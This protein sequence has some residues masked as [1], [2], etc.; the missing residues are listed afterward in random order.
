M[1]STP[2]QTFLDILQNQSICL[3]GKEQRKFR[4]IPKP[5]HLLSRH[6]KSLYQ[7]PAN[8]ILIIDEIEHLD[9]HLNNEEFINLQ[10]KI[11]CGEWSIINSLD[12]K[13]TVHLLL[14]FFLSI[15]DS[16]IDDEFISHLEKND[17]VEK[18]VLLHQ[19]L[20]LGILT[21]ICSV[22]DIFK[23]EDT[24]NKLDD[25]I[26]LVFIQLAG[27]FSPERP[28]WIPTDTL[29][30]STSGEH[31]MT[32]NFKLPQMPKFFQDWTG[33][34]KEFRRK[35]SVPVWNIYETLQYIYKTYNI[36]ED[37]SSIILSDGCRQ[38]ESDKS[39]SSDSVGN[40][41]D[42]N[43][44]VSANASNVTLDY[45]HEA[46]TEPNLENKIDREV[47]QGLSPLEAVHSA[48]LEET[49]KEV[50]RMTQSQDQ[51]MNPNGN[52]NSPRDKD[53]IIQH[54]I[55]SQDEIKIE[56]SFLSASVSLDA[57]QKQ[58]HASGDAEALP[59]GQEIALHEV[60][61]NQDHRSVTK[62]HPYERFGS[63]SPDLIVPD[64]DTH[65]PDENLQGQ[66]HVVDMN[67]SSP[68]SNHTAQENDSI[69]LFLPV[70]N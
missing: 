46:I 12:I 34:G 61:L 11:N 22:L 23:I 35:M 25:N 21:T 33:I 65:V 40:V 67:D 29:Q 14:I 50:Q 15:K 3:H 39:N 36:T 28:S 52:R 49:Q 18:N 62:N 13:L 37:E 10:S 42:S 69:V 1:M 32:L 19:R 64:Q 66:F 30:L 5:I 41:A 57:S 24:E 17:T 60:E 56:S 45:L 59:S 44:S 38:I 54:P 9:Y 16:L 8:R 43:V 27:I 58:I 47:Y 55:E 31:S 26:D 6:L 2:S 63:I 68:K 51:N 7:I 70:S 20:E 48:D 53:D 4:W